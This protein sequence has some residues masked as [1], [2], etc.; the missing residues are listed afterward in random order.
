MDGDNYNEREDYSDLD[1]RAFS[2]GD[3]NWD[4]QAA[5]QEANYA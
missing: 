4:K 1:A 2:S 3:S 5:P